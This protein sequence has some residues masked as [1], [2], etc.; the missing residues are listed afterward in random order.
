MKRYPRLAIYTIEEISE[1]LGIGIRTIREKLKAVNYPRNGRKYLILGKDVP[2]IFFTPS[3]PR[4]ERKKTIRKQ[5]DNQLTS[6]EIEVI[7]ENQ[8]QLDL[9]NEKESTN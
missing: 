8:I 9:T 3:K 4:I 1:Q 7:N 2:K 6:Q 5:K